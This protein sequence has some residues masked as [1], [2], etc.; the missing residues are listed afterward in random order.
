MDDEQMILKKRAEAIAGSRTDQKT[1]VRDVLSVVEFMLIPEH[2]AVAGNFVQEVIPLTEITPIPG[3]P[4]FIIGV[5]NLRG[6]IVSLLNLKI[7]FG[8]KEK[9]LTDFNKVIILRNETVEFG[10]VADVIVGTRLVQMD[11]I[12]PPPLTLDKTAS[13]LVIG[14]SADGIILLDADKM[15]KSNHLIVNLKSKQ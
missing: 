8:L 9:G 15:L 11:A 12:S 4:S 14:I 3:A 13:E 10:I 1:E 6:K 7:K 2:Y 5:I